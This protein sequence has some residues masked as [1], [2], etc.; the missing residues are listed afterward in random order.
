MSHTYHRTKVDLNAQQNGITGGVLEC[1]CP[2]LALVIAEG[3]PKAIKRY[4]RLMTVRMKWRGEN[5][6]G[7]SDD[8]DDDIQEEEEVAQVL[9][10]GE[11]WAGMGTKR[12]FHNFSFQSC[13]TS[14]AARK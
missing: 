14:E 3:G 12:M 2:K 4:V 8:D 5:F 10:G 13:A 11:V 1:S 7:E 6:H 9:P